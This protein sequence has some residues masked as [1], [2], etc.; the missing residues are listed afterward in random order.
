MA[1]EERGLS[2]AAEANRGRGGSDFFKTTIEPSD[3]PTRTTASAIRNCRVEYCFGLCS[4]CF[5]WFACF[6]GCPLILRDKTT[7][8][9]R[10]SCQLIIL[11]NKGGVAR[12][13]ND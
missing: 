3:T 9:G 13:N 2:G 8:P 1:E 12:I 10:V 6:M 11:R 7:T 4:G 5:G